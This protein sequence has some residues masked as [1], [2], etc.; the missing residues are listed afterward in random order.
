MPV[1]QGWTIG[2][3]L[4]HADAYYEAGVELDTLPRVGVGSICRRQAT[5]RACSILAWL[6]GEGFKLHAFGFKIVGL[7]AAAASLASADSMA[8][9]AGAMK[10]PPLPGHTHA[11][12][13]NCL[14]YALEWRGRVLE[15]LEKG[16][17]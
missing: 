7:R 3:Y 4:R 2:D 11:S 15:S 14:E 17:V 10:N 8:W 5:T 13:S 12:C 16:E 9:S 1:L 6:A